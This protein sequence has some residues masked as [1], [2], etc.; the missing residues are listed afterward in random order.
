MT[1]KV[2]KP[3]VIRDLAASWWHKLKTDE[4][5]NLIGTHQIYLKDRT[6][7]KTIVLSEN[8]PL[9][10]ADLA[11][12]RAFYDWDHFFEENISRHVLPFTARAKSSIIL[13]YDNRVKSTGYSN[14]VAPRIG[15]LL[16]C[17]FVSA[18]RQQDR[19]ADFAEIFETIW[20]PRFGPRI[21]KWIYILHALR[22]AAD[23]AR[24]AVVAAVVD[25]VVRAFG[26]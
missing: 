3:I 11:I 24:I 21:A 10:E 4:N 25:R 17:L 13:R 1:K 2:D 19:L 15:Q 14:E 9:A 7:I 12:R 20:S 26:L 6:G 18:D 8:M 5:G 16:I 22:S 23:I